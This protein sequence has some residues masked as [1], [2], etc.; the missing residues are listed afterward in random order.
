LAAYCALSIAA[1]NWTELVSQNSEGDLALGA[2]EWPSLSADGRYVAFQ[3]VAYNLVSDDANGVTDIFVRDM[4][5]GSTTRVS[6]D[7]LGVEGNADSEW[8][9]LS[10]DGRFVTFLSAA[11]NLVPGDTN[12]AQDV[13][14]HDRETGQTRR[15]SVD[16]AGVQG[17]ADSYF[18][19]RISA[20]GRY[21][22]FASHASNLVAGDDNGQLD[23]FVHDR[24]SGVT[25]RVSVDSFGQQG[26]AYSWLPDISADGRFVS[27]ASGASNLVAGDDNGAIDVFVHD[28]W[29]G[30]TT[31]VSVDSEGNGG[32]GESSYPRL[33]GNGRFVA[34][35][36]NAAN[37]V[38]NDTNEYFDVFVHDRETGATTCVSRNNTGAVNDGNAELPVISGDGRYV[39]FHASAGNLLP[40]DT[41]GTWDV[42]L[43]DRQTGRLS[44]Q[45]V[46]SRGEQGNNHSFGAE[47]SSNGR[48]VAFHSFAYN[49]VDRQVNGLP[50]LFM[51][52]MH[53]IQVDS[54]S[55][56]SVAIGQTTAVTVTGARFVSGAIPGMSGGVKL[57]N[58]VFLDEQTITFDVE[59]PADAQPG[60][61][62]LAVTLMGDGPGVDAGVLEVCIDCVTL[63]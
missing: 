60:Q 23:V 38:A 5:L 56:A 54:I 40:G 59:V 10:A 13:F 16:S 42:F 29:S 58:V 46:A 3:S 50:H 27:F 31:R 39:A 33:S 34:F 44:R 26:D 62:D 25:S 30:E 61:V 48:Y 36:S 17:N 18:D 49:V 19:P 11:S 22:A 45:S 4:R 28:R 9:S 20:D 32:D 47:M 8:P 6:I 35:H 43:R 14:V 53:D 2:S 37:L 41:N 7:S 63:F 55:P 21:V 52:S 1:C 12:G 15:V 57:K 51:R 24:Q